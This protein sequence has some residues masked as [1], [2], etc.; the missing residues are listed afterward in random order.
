MHQEMECIS[1][2]KTRNP[3]V[4]GAKVSLTT[5]LKEGFVLGACVM[6]GNSYDGHTLASALAQ[7]QP[8]SHMPINTAVVC[9]G[10]W[11]N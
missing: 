5:T 1:T 11:L 8:Q 10:A 9:I 7:S 6:P 4:F 2:G 3:Y